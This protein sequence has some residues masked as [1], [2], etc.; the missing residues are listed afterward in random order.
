[1]AYVPPWAV[2]VVTVAVCALAT[3]IRMGV[4]DWQS[5]VTGTLPETTSSTDTDSAQ[6][7]F[8]NATETQWC[9]DGT[10]GSQWCFAANNTQRGALEVRHRAYTGAVPTV[11]MHWLLPEVNGTLP[12][13]QGFD[14]GSPVPVHKSVAITA[15]TMGDYTLV[16]GVSPQ[17]YPCGGVVGTTA[18]GDTMHMDQMY[19]STNAG[20]TAWYVFVAERFQSTIVTVYILFSSHLVCDTS[21][22][23]YRANAP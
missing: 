4:R 22:G 16:P 18:T 20:R 6:S 15:P 12:V 14:G 8:T 1:M 9:V 23:T 11:K 10:N 7:V 3:S 5:D 2:A 17:W 13:I 19:L 21:S